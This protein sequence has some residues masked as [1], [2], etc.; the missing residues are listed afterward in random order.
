MHRKHV[1][2]DVQVALSLM[3]PVMAP[4]KQVCLLLVIDTWISMLTLIDSVKRIQVGHINNFIDTNAHSTSNLCDRKLNSH[5]CRG[6]LHAVRGAELGRDVFDTDTSWPCIRCYCRSI[7]PNLD[8]LRD[9]QGRS[10]QRVSSYRQKRHS[11]YRRSHTRSRR[12]CHSNII[13]FLLLPK[14][15]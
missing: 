9:C 7:N 4:L 10:Y 14:T 3:M 1:L 6:Q 5:G 8:Q 11:G 2:L 12:P 13:D 15:T